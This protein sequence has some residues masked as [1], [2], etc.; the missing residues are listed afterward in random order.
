MDKYE[1]AMLALLLVKE[2][3]K[4]DVTVED[5]TAKIIQHNKSIQ[6]I[7]AVAEKEMGEYGVQ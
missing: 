6:K 5:L 7:M 4:K 1:A 3:T 2:F